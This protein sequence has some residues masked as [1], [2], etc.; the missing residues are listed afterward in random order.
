MISASARTQRSHLQPTVQPGRARQAIEEQCLRR[1]LNGARASWRRVSQAPGKSTSSM[2]CGDRSQRRPARSLRRAPRLEESRHYQPV[3]A[4]YPH[5]VSH[6]TLGIKIIDKAKV[7]WEIA[8]RLKT[9]P[10]SRKR[11]MRE[12]Q[13]NSPRDQIG[14]PRHRIPYRG[15]K[16]YASDRIGMRK[17]RAEM[18]AKPVIATCAAFPTRI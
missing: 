10:I 8:Y 2:R 6:Q 4:E 15:R 17:R 11:S 5:F 1:K 14:G 3:Q 7:S 13:S 18:R 9:R 16:A 12:S